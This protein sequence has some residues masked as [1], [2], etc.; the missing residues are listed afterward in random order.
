VLPPNRASTGFEMSIY[1]LN[2]GPPD[3]VD[4]ADWKYMN[5]MVH[6]RSVVLKFGTAF[7]LAGFLFAQVNT[8]V[9]FTITSDY[10][11][12]SSMIWGACALLWWNA[13]ARRAKFTD[14]N[15]FVWGAYVW[16]VS[17]L[18]ISPFE[19]EINSTLEL[20]KRDYCLSCV[21]GVFCV[22]LG[23][24]P[25]TAKELA[26]SEHV[27][28]SKMGG[29]ASFPIRVGMLGASCCVVCGGKLG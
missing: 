29:P 27:S 16:I 17:L 11:A 12:L 23:G 7:Y 20:L 19:K 26:A 5:D 25:K 21:G 2:G 1:L 3:K 24:S 6:G 4:V 18:Y 14:P 13:M 10:S 22:H 9:T 8:W 15:K 28:L